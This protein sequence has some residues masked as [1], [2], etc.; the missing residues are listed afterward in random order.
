MSTT[1]AQLPSTQSAVAAPARR[2]RLTLTTVPVHTPTAGEVVIRVEWCASSPLDLHMADGGLVVSSWPF[3]VGT[4]GVAGTVVA[5]ASEGDLKGLRVGDSVISFAWGS[6]KMANTQQYVTV[7]AYLVSRIPEGISKPAASTVSVNLVTVFHTV[8]KDLGL[9]LP[10]PIP[11]G[12]TPKAADAAILI[13]G[14]SSSVGM[15]ALQVLRHWGYRNLIAVSSGRHHDNLRSLGATVC[16]D[17]TKPG[18]EAAIVKHIGAAGVPYIIDCIGSVEGT[19]RPLSKIAH[20]GTRVAIM[21]PMIIRDATEEEEPLYESN[22][23][24][25]LPGE[26]AEGV[27]LRGVRTHFYLENEFFKDTLQSEI[28]PSLLAQGIVKPNNYRLVEGASLLERA[29]KA[30]DLLRQRAASGERLVWRVAEE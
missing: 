30:L 5:T 11:S 17:Y 10:W 22:P 2:A 4:G 15:Y 23:A 18:V 9:D 20:N 7:P 24:N 21:L 16:F 27:I 25:V 12:W 6:D 3:V 28:V 1:T 26:W 14:A 13:W 8:T 29:Q 19:L